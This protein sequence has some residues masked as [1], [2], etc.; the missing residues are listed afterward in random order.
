MPLLAIAAADID[1][2]GR[3]IEADLP[4]AWL[5]EELADTEARASVPGHVSARLSRSGA[6]VVVRGRVHSMLDIPCARC[7]GP[8]KLDIDADLSLLLK[9]V[10]SLASAHEKRA[11]SKPS[12]G[13]AKKASKGQERQGGAEK[14]AGAARKDRGSSGKKSS[15]GKGRGEDLPEYEFGSDEADLDAYDGELVVLDGFV[16]EAILLELPIFPLCSESCAG[17]RPAS[18][19]VAEGGASPPLDPRL[20]PLRALRASLAQSQSRAEPAEPRK[21]NGEQTKVH[22]ASHAVVEALQEK[23]TKKE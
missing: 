10:P 14:D 22:D 20:M 19:E 9:P 8:A 18:P 1:A 2:S 15:K 3:S 7:L 4:V 17:I 16:R 11:E 6:E 23:K 12:E 21:S 5:N 13:S